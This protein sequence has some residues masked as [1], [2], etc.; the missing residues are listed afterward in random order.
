MIIPDKEVEKK[1]AVLRIR[2]A[3][4]RIR[5]DH[6][7]IP[8][9]DPNIFYSGTYMKSRMQD[10]FFLLLLSGATSK[11][12]IDSQKDLGSEIRKKFFPDPEGKSNGSRIR[13]TGSVT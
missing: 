1:D 3:L 11:I 12:L 5:I 6:F 2:D 7:L 13:N 8:D 4:S 9:P 10:Y